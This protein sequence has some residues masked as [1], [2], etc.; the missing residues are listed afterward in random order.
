MKEIGLFGILLGAL[1]AVF[2]IFVTE[3]VRTAFKT[4]LI[5]FKASAYLQSIMNT[6]VNDK[7]MMDAAALARIWSDERLKLVNSFGTRK[8][9]A[10]DSDAMTALDKKHRDA[11]SAGFKDESSVSKMLSS[12]TDLASS[13]TALAA[14]DDLLMRTEDDLRKNVSWLSDDDAAYL[15]WS[16]AH[17]A[18]VVRQKLMLVVANTRL[19]LAHAREPKMNRERATPIMEQLFSA[20]IDALRS[21]FPL[22]ERAERVRRMNLLELIVFKLND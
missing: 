11:M 3:L 5:A 18:V 13:P 14:L 20:L 7:T 16:A 6:I 19:L 1:G 12:F 10:G 15:G 8:L 4:R 22:R 2:A 21:F 9:T 17:H